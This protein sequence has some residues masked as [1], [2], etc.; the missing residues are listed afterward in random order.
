MRAAPAEGPI[1]K[2]WTGLHSL[3]VEYDS[4]FS[5]KP[6][7]RVLV[8][9]D[10]ELTSDIPV[11]LRPYGMAPRQWK[12]LKEGVEHMLGMGI[13]EPCLCASPMI[14]MKVP[15]KDPQPCIDYRKLNAIM[16][17]QTYPI[18][19]IEERAGKV[20]MVNYVTTLDLV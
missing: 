13:I 17:D 11:R 2:Q 9:Y 7:R 15:G 20:S 5:G 4:L 14:L 1:E 6:G 18:P 16:N 3:I 19:N 8:C 12:I 10:I